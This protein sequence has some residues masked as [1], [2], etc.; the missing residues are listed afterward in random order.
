MGSRLPLTGRSQRFEVTYF[1]LSALFGAALLIWAPPPTSLESQLPG[2][3]VTL[4]AVALVTCGCVGLI[5]SY[6]RGHFVTGL[7]LERAALLTAAAAG[8]LYD[9]AVF[10]RAGW[11]ATGAA[12]WVSAYTVSCLLRARDISTV[13][14]DLTGS[15]ERT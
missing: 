6:W 4:W 2:W 10:S 12:V 3:V 5:G 14:A 15:Q 11:G 9:V 7:L 13:L 8:T 1:V